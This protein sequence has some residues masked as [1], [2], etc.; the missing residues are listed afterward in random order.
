MP[1]APPVLPPGERYWPFT[2]DPSSPIPFDE[3]GWDVQVYSRDRHTW[4]N[5]EP[6]DAHHG[7]DC[8]GYPG[9]HRITRYDQM[10]FR[11]RNHIMTSIKAEGYGSVVL[12]PDR[13]LDMS[14]GEGVIRF[15]ISTFRSSDRD[16]IDIWVSPYDVNLPVPAQSWAPG[17]NGPPRDGI[18]VEMTAEG[19]LCPRF[20]RNF[21]V[22]ELRCESRPLS[23]RIV[24]SATRRNTVEIRL[25]A[26][27]V[28]VSMPNDGI[29]FADVALP[30]SLP[31]SQGVVQ[32]SHKSYNPTKCEFNCGGAPRAANTWHWD[33]IFIAP[34]VGFTIIR[35]DKRHL[36]GAGG[37]VTFRSAAPANGKLR[38]SAIGMAPDVS[39]DGGRTWQ[40]PVALPVGKTNDPDMQYFTPIPAGTVQVSFRPGRPIAFGGR[41]G[42]RGSHVTSPSGRVEQGQSLSR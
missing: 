2:V 28:K 22:T 40:Q 38:F 14:G 4:L 9:Q 35:G 30:A 42:T 19:N 34:S 8:A 5:P 16:W 15:D 21:V 36:D 33:E 23:D 26:N 32:F 27:R 20:V 7:M 39:F 11:C 18:F 41:S 13:L 37:T 6:M 31:F 3:A 12:T 1:P 17:V 10:V 25:S 29:V 24:V